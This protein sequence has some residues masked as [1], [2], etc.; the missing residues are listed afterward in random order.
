MT[1]IALCEAGY[2]QGA[3]G[4][5]AINAEFAGCLTDAGFLTASSFSRNLR[6]LRRF[7][8]SQNSTVREVALRPAWVQPRARA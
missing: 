7:K 6:N 5:I 4:V 3:A 8:E 1:G 2:L